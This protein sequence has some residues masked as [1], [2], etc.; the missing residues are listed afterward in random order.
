MRQTAAGLELSVAQSDRQAL[1]TVL[2]LELDH[3]ALDLAA[4]EV[5]ASPSLTAGA[6]PYQSAP[7]TSVYAA[8]IGTR[9]RQS[10][11]GSSA[12]SRGFRKQ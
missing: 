3:A 6:T 10:L 9:E 5:P 8:S 1:D 7:S 12:R 4:V 2:A 11:F